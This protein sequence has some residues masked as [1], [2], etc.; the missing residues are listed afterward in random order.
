MEENI[1][2]LLLDD[3]DDTLVLQRTILESY[4]FAVESAI[5]GLDGLEKLKTFTP[6]I[7][8]SDIL[9]PHMDGFEFCRRVKAD[10]SFKNIPVVFYSA[11]YTDESDKSLALDVGAE[12]FITK[13]IEIDKFLE[14]IVTILKQSKEEKS[15]KETTQ[16]IEFD[17]KHYEVQAKML[18][19]KLHELEEQNKKLQKSEANYKRLIE[20]LSGDYFI[21]R[22][23]TNGVLTYVSPTVKET[24]GYNFEEFLSHPYNDFLTPDPINDKVEKYTNDALNGTPP[25]MYEIEV[26]AKDKTKKFLQIS[27]HPLYDEDGNIIGVE[28]I[29]HNITLQ[30]ITQFLEEEALKKF[31][32]GMVDMIKAFSMAIEK[33]DSYTAGHQTRVS[34]LSILIGNK[35]GWDKNRIEG[36]QLGALIHDIGKIA[37]PIEILSKP[38]HLLPIEFS[39]IQIHAQ[40][41]FDILKDIDF[42]WPIAPMIHQHH[43]RI[44]GTGYPLGLKGDEILEEAKILAIADVVEA[45]ASH[46]PYRP[47][48][49][50]DA[51]I[52]EIQ[53]GKGTLYDSH[54]VD[55][56]IEVLE[57]NKNL[58][59]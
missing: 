17:Q 2:V 1:K 20:G 45:V 26:Y 16:D 19:K 54:I 43:E 18:D 55:V 24:M 56:C 15:P 22:H 59:D 49:G 31:H 38:G 12:G 4:G 36:L 58:L 37:V 28:G 52:Q 25:P 14:I 53:N 3:S 27:E 8:I 30:K 5:D 29:A 32:D 42:P 23:D 9:M 21:F 13:P 44:D 10:D 11:Q 47:A 35:L 7:I 41:G 6:D 39:L 33:R 57:E 46:R 34:E 48:L 50:I 40:V 51:A